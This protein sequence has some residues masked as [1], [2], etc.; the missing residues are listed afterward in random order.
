[1]TVKVTGFTIEDAFEAKT[2]DFR[3]KYHESGVVRGNVH[4]TAAGSVLTQDKGKVFSI[5]VGTFPR[6]KI[7]SEAVRDFNIDL[8][9]VNF[10]FDRAMKHSHG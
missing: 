10:E 9:T 4:D 1:M 2:K 6:T 7:G 5:K 8:D 3:N